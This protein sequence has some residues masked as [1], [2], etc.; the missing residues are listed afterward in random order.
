MMAWSVLTSALFLFQPRA[1]QV[2]VITDD[3]FKAQFILIGL[4]QC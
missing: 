3:I 1:F 4:F 2:Q